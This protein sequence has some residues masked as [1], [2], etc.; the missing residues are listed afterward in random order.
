MPTKKSGIR[1]RSSCLSAWNAPLALCHAAG[2]K[3][4]RLS[5]DL[6]F[7]LEAVKFSA[8]KTFSCHLNLHVQNTNLPVWCK[9]SDVT[10][11]ASKQMFIYQHRD[12]Y[13]PAIQLMWACVI[14]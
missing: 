1:Q 5:Q 14:Q 10:L 4:T 6:F 3:Q 8:K 7:T 9:E 12:V 13:L 11:Y 2:N